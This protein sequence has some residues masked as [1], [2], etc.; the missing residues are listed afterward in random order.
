MAGKYY[1]IV[2]G[3][4][5]DIADWFE[6]QVYDAAPGFGTEF[7]GESFQKA[8]DSETAMTLSTYTIDGKQSITAVKKGYF[9]TFYN[10]PLWS[11][12]A[13]G[14][15]SIK[16]SDNTLTIGYTTYRPEDFRCNTIPHE[17]IILLVGGGG[18]GGG[19][20]YFS[21]GKNKSGYARVAGGAGGGGA[22]TVGRIRLNNDMPYTIVVGKGGGAGTS[23]S[24]GSSGAGSDGGIGAGTYLQDNKSTTV[25]LSA[26][27]GKG[28]TTGKPLGNDSATPGTGGLGGAAS[29]STHSM[30]IS[31]ASVKGGQGNYYA[32]RNK[33]A[34]ADLQYA[35]HPETGAPNWTD[36]G[37]DNNGSYEN[38]DKESDSYYSGGC[39]YG[40]GDYFSYGT[41]SDGSKGGGGTAGT[42]VS[43]GHTG[44]VAIWY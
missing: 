24:S 33:T 37:L 30:L 10:A 9:P 42:T 38:A 14:S 8:G 15:F 28:G 7:V 41:F 26:N 25:I 32:N 12:A 19:C 2:D 39:S 6:P 5:V 36:R 4:K 13:T 43:A 31:K 22:V 27:G 18:G 44:Y 3:V 21:P 35:P 29:T 17:L 1:Q 11:T 23:H 34:R 20:G 40:Y 16:R